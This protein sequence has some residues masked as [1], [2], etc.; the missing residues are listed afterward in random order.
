MGRFFHDGMGRR[1]DVVR[2]LQ[3]GNLLSLSESFYKEWI[4]RF[5]V[6]RIHFENG[7]GGR[8]DV[9]TQL[10]CLG[11]KQ[12][13]GNI[14]SKAEGVSSGVEEASYIFER[15]GIKVFERIGDGVKIFPGT[16]MIKIEGSASTILFLERMVLDILQRMCG[17]ATLTSSV[18]NNVKDEVFVAATRKTPL[19]YLDK[20]AVYCG[21]GLT[22]RL[23]LW[24]GVLLK[25]NHLSLLGKEH[26]KQS[27]HDF[28]DRSILRAGMAPSL[29]FEVEVNSGEEALFAAS[30]LARVKDKLQVPVL[31]LLDNIPPESLKGIVRLLQEKGLY[32]WLL[33]EASGGITQTNVADYTGCGIDVASLGE[34]THSP[35]VID[36]CLEVGSTPE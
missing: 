23:G 28:V 7:A 5:V 4:D 6:E 27:L 24:D 10:T 25:D 2:A 18:I 21:G 31:L 15:F 13:S 32:P 29:F 34:L 8:G 12:C 3:H 16:S 20:K 1:E 26:L 14:L 35:K 19:G 22:H 33:L 36:I 9:T 17:I 11:E 30:E